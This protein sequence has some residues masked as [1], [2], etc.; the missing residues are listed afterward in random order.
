VSRASESAS[1]VT[2]ALA[3]FTGTEAADWHLVFKARYGMEVVFTSIARVKGDGDVA[4]QIFTCATAVDP[5]LVAGLTPHYGEVNASSVALDPAQLVLGD[6]MRAVVAQ[7]TFGI[8]D[9]ALTAQLRALADSANAVLVEDSAHCVARLAT[10]DA[11]NPFADV[12]IHSFGV[13]KVLPTR[14]GGAVW[15]N[16][17]MKDQALRDH[18]TAS[19]I[20]LPVIGAK[21]DR[22]ARSYL[23]QM[24]LLRRLPAGLA[25]RTRNALTAVG[26]YEPAIAPVELAGGLSHKPMR[27]SHWVTEAMAD[28]M[29]QLPRIEQRRTAVV[30][31]YR[32]A[33]PAGAQIPASIT[34][35]Q[36]LVRFP[37]FAPHAALA[38]ECFDALNSAGLRPGRWYRPALFPGVADPAV[39]N[40]VPGDG[41]LAATED[42]IER[43]VNLP[44][45][46][47]LDTAHRVVDVIVRVLGEAA[48]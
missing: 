32:E 46:V 25:K 6:S 27:P 37:F 31:Y 28:A 19:L 8:V 1:A 44:T 15:V 30:A 40:Y 7:H 17:D 10:D 23:T 39:Y 18:L 9:N 12:S 38:E 36:P 2:A 11:G 41:A 43:V 13:E 24:R 5:I 33:L 26:L 3:E 4:T 16:P 20:A 48:R 21:V 47:D 29:H 35:P 14:F 34:T 45:D 42:L 22:A